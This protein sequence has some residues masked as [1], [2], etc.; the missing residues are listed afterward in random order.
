MA[1]AALPALV[2]SVFRATIIGFQTF[3]LVQILLEVSLIATW[4]LR[5]KLGYGV[6]IAVV[7]SVLWA[8]TFA[9]LSKIGPVSDSKVFMVLFA[10][11]AVLLL[12]KR[13][14]W[15]CVAFISLSMMS[16]SL[17]AVNQYFQFDLDFETYK[18][19]P[20]AW[21]LTSWNMIVFST[22]VAM[23]GKKMVLKIQQQSEQ[24]SLLA[25]KLQKISSRVPG[26]VYQYRLRP[27]GSSHFPYASA[28]I[29]QI[30]RLKPEDVVQDASMVFQRLHPD[31]IE[32]IQ[33]TIL[34]SAKTLLPWR[35][36][37]R[38]IDPDGS[39]RWLSGNAKPEREADGSVLW[40]GMITDIT[41]KKADE[42]L[43]EEF[44]ATVSHELRT[45]LTAIN[46]ALKII[47]NGAIEHDP[48]KL[49]QLLK[50]AASNTD[51]LLELINDILD[52]EKL[53]KQEFS[54]QKEWTDLHQL[55]QECIEQNQS[56]AQQYH[57]SLKCCNNDAVQAYLDVGRFKQVLTNLISNACKYSKAGGVVELDY[58]QTDDGLTV[59]V[60]D[61]GEGIPEAFIASLFDKFTQAD[62]ST[63]R[64]V[65]G[66]GL[67]L[68]I[69]KSIVEHHGGKI[70]VNTKEG[71]GSCFII[72]LPVQEDL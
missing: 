39:I 8:A 45:P 43:K 26:V 33:Q 58:A 31:D 11:T 16:F 60:K 9:A 2:V 61:Y 53:S 5:D 3:M 46:G 47:L 7:L 30:Y 17:L 49:K 71:Q 24:A 15:S 59:S 50:I 72:R 37:Y 63:T 36:E 41:Q 42:K 27:D 57:V 6:R 65:G 54:L 4:L 22:L 51:R 32:Q 64:R 70:L 48:V 20:M 29:E 25:A 69:V 67:G 14:A 19:H 1:I 34:D 66:T 55:I 52:I 28:G 18:H 40:H 10:F 56:Y 23:M 62:S 68:S 44:V 12:P 38:V 13:F 21:F 35:H